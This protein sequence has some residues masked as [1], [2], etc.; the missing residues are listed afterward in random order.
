MSLYKRSDSPHWW[1]KISHSG[2]TIQRSTGTKDKSEAQEYHDKLKASLW[3][4]QRLG[5]RP[6]RSWKEAAVRWLAETSEKVTHQE[7]VRTFRWL[8]SLLGDLMLD[9]MTLDVLDG[10]KVAK[11]KVAGKPTVNRYLAL[12]RAVLLRARDEWE[13]ID[14]TPKVK[15]FKEGPGRERSITVEQAATILSELPAHQRDVVLFALATGL[16]QSNVLG[17]EW[18]HVNLDAGHAWVGAAQSKNRKP[19]SV[20]LNATALQ[21]LS[22][23]LGKHPERVFTYRGRPLAWANT[24]AWRSALKRAG[25]ENFRWHDLRHSW[26]SWHRQAGTPTHGLQK[27]GGWRSSVMVERYAHLAPD[28]LATAANRLDPLLGGYDLATLEKEKGSVRGST[29]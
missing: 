18:S 29:P 14:R 19:I 4:Q 9:E 20:P 12:I 2:T 24:L 26:A 15:L 13:W 6:R 28:H 16:R 23:Q 8:D 21:V 7:D 3:E 1:V 11:L 25:I 5:I 17:L 10:I 27:L 22:R